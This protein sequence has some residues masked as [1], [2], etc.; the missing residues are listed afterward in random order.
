MTNIPDSHRD[1]LEADTAILATVGADGRPQLSAVWFLAEGDEIKVSLNTD[2]QKAKN[3]RANPA[4]NLFI[5]DRATPSR[6]L[7]I[8]G[9]AEIADDPDYV[10]AARVGQK[11]GA[12]LKAFDGDNAHRLVVTI[13][14][15]RVNA[16]DMAAG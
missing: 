12:D 16:V 5:L 4:V 6:Y 10:F 3:L 9:D 15:V 7:E 2:R 8:R 13:K 1:L 14:P 11:Y